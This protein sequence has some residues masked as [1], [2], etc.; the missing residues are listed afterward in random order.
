MI[1]KIDLE[2]VSLEVVAKKINEIIP[3][4]NILIEWRI[5]ELEKDWNE[6][7]YGKR[8]TNEQKIADIKIMTAIAEAFNKKED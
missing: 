7:T 3:A 4:L 2:N 8:I 5:R 6:I 1:E